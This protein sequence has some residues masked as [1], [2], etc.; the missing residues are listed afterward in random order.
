MLDDPHAR[1]VYLTH[2]I[3]PHGDHVP[4]PPALVD[5]PATLS[6][7]DRGDH[8]GES[9]RH[10]AVRPQ[11]MLAERHNQAAVSAAFGHRGLTTSPLYTGR[12]DGSRRAC[13]RQRSVRLCRDRPPIAPQR[14]DRIDAFTRRVGTPS[15]SQRQ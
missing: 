6:V 5:G 1:R 2:E 13:Q 8:S 11:R 4:H 14:I 3:E 12:R 9:L 15:T 7:A 10:A